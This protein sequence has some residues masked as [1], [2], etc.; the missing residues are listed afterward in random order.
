MSTTDS[1]TPKSSSSNSSQ[2]HQH[3]L[4]KSVRPT[5]ARIAAESKPAAL[6]ERLRSLKILH[7]RV[8]PFRIARALRVES[9]LRAKS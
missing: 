8:E 5:A 1:A 4:S 2:T 3:A 7:R 9:V 6:I